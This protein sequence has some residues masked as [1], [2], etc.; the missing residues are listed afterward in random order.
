MHVHL[1]EFW[2]VFVSEALAEREVAG[3]GGVTSDARL[4]EAVRGGDV[5]AYGVLY[6][7]H[8]AAAQRAAGTFTASAAEQEDLVAEAF[9]RVLR[10]LRGGRGPAD[11]FRSY[12]VTTMRNILIDWRRRDASV[13]PVAEVPE[14]RAATGSDEVVGARL[15]AVL[16]ADAFACLPERWRVVLWRTEIEGETPAQVAPLLGMTPNSVSALAY[17]AREGLR[18]AYLDQH[19]RPAVRRGCD[20]VATELAG[21]VRGRFPTRKAQR[22]AAHVRD[23]PDCREVAAG[24]RR[25]NGELPGISAIA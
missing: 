3:S 15:H 5:T 6:R 16:V 2:E 21:W 25:L 19:A 23:C 1:H 4:I 10:V 8:V 7:R 12:L 24:L 13:S 14:L 18:Q 11:G 9:A 22:I 17:R 20:G